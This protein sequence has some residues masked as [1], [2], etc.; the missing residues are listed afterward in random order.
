LYEIRYVRGHD[1]RILKRAALTVE[2]TT[3]SLEAPAKV[4]AGSRISVRWT[5]PDLAGDF[6]AIANRGSGPY[7]YLDFAYTSAGSPA[8]LAAPFRPGRFEIRY[9]SGD[10]KEVLAAIPVRVVR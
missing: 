8:S 2:E 10:S 6:I 9:I 5:G 4:V 7:R 1:G 3:P